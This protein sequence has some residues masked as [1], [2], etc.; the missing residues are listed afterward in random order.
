ML[1][2]DVPVRRARAQLL[3]GRDVLFAVFVR[4]DV[5][6]NGVLREFGATVQHV[7]RVLRI[8][9]LLELRRD[10]RVPLSVEER[11]NGS[12]PDGL[13]IPI[14]DTLCAC[15][16]FGCCRSWLRLL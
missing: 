6:R 11:T 8:A 10:D 14:R 9:H 5:A 15:V 4:I 2:G 3:G 16:A 7:A 13:G 1:V 12:P